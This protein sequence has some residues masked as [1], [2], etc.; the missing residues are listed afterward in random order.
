M[1]TLS[2]KAHNSHYIANVSYDVPW[3]NPA[4]QCYQS[5][6]P[7][8]QVLRLTKSETPINQNLW[9]DGLKAVAP[10]VKTSR[11]LQQLALK[12]GGHHE[13]RK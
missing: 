8:R 9:Q 7:P 2:N 1:D 12:M 11:E 13:D 10:A 4:L 6:T 3:Q 5:L